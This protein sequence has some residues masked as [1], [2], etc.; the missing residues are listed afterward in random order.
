LLDNLILSESEFE[1][2]R[3]KI[4]TLHQKRLF[5]TALSDSKPKVPKPIPTNS[6][7]YFTGLG[8]RLVSFLCG[9]AVASGVGYYFLYKE[10]KESNE[11]F[12]RRL[13]DIEK[14]FQSQSKE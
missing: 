9:F 4:V 14:Q 7:G 5:S 1:M 10:L 6:E 3:H 8:N 12:E 13:L 11:S 2:L